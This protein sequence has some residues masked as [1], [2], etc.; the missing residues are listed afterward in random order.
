MLTKNFVMPDTDSV[1]AMCAMLFGEGSAVT[2]IDAPADTAFVG[3]MVCDDN[4]GVA[5]CYCDMDFAAYSSSA[6]SMMN[7]DIANE[8]IEAG[9]LSEEA[10]GNLYEVMN[11]FSS[12]YM[13][14]K[15]DHLRLL[16]LEQGDFWVIPFP[17]EITHVSIT[18]PGF[19]SGTFS[20]AIK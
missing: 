10:R 18:V 14:D 12:L 17:T 16:S 3:R 11:V 13:D 15:S 6:L 1:T 2:P 7:A 20:F 19:G 9:A 5:S 4:I 8:F